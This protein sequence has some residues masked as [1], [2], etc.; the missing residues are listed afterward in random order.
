MKENS[1]PHEDV[2]TAALGVQSRTAQQAVIFLTI[3]YLLIF[4][5]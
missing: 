5:E 3:G 1:F 2:G 4:D